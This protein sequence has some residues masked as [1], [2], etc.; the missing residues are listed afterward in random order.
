MYVIK[1]ILT[2]SCVIYFERLLLF[3]HILIYIIFV[4]NQHFLGPW[5]LMSLFLLSDWSFKQTHVFD[6]EA[7]N[8]FGQSRGERF[9]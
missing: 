5:D 1:Q 7:R 4:F 9:Y 2:P 3:L 8:L 6:D